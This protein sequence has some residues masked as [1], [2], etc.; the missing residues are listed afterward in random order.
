MKISEFR[1]RSYMVSTQ[2]RAT[3]RRGNV[4]ARKRGRATSTTMPSSPQKACYACSTRR[5][6]NPPTPVR[7]RGTSGRRD[8]LRVVR[9]AAAKRVNGMGSRRKVRDEKRRKG[10]GSTSFKRREIPGLVECGEPLVL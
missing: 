1:K 10:G 4:I 5:S 6:E 8:L 2:T 3:T 7:L 9:K